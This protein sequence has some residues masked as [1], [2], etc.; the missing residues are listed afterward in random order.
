MRSMMTATSPELNRSVEGGTTLFS[1]LGPI[2]VPTGNRLGAPIM[3]RTP[4]G[5]A[6]PACSRP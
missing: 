5:A 6:M 3:P 2:S 1:L 4:F